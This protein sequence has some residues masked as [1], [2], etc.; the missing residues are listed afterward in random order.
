VCGRLVV[1][2]VET[3]E[4]IFF[5][6]TFVISTLIAVFSL[7]CT[8]EYSPVSCATCEGGELVTLKYDT[9]S[10]F[11]DTTLVFISPFEKTDTLLNP[12][13]ILESWKEGD[14]LVY[15]SGVLTFSE[16]QLADTLLLIPTAF[17][18][19]FLITDVSLV[20]DSP[21]GVCACP[22]IISVD[23]KINGTAFQLD[24]LPIILKQRDQ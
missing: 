24:D 11:R 13:E 20:F 23:L 14:P 2:I 10:T 9:P 15:T 21:V 16:K 22:Q 17:D 5:P 18:T 8:N 19:S 7:D 4:K 1:Y 3:M 12:T 6:R